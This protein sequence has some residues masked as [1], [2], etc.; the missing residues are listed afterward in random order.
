MVRYFCYSNFLAS[1]GS[2]SLAS[3]SYMFI[4][5]Y[6]DALAFVGLTFIYNYSL[7]YDG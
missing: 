3:T 2:D 4:Y 5:K 6:S 7:A 1:I